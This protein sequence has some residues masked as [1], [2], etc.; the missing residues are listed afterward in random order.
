MMLIV[1]DK[2]R[3]ALAEPITYQALIQKTIG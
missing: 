2:E 1:S 3:M